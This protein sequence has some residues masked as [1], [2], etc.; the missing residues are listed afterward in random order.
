LRVGIGD[1][2]S[3][4]KQIDFVL[5]EFDKNES[6]ALPLILDKIEEMTLSFCTIGIDRTMSQ[7][8]S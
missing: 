2:F 4:G 5:G 8:N 1:N 7:Y 3:K 6:A